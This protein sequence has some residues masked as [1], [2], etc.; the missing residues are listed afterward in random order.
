MQIKT[1]MRYYFTSVGM[2]NIKKT[3]DKHW[4]GCGETEMLIHCETLNW[5]NYNGKLCSLKINKK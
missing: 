2:A 1:T 3:N 4:Q 5:C